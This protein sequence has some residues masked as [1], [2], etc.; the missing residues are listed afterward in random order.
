MTD[1]KMSNKSPEMIDIVFDLDGG[2]LPAA[3]PFA[4]WAALVCRVPQLAEEKFVGVLPLRGTG[5]NE[6]LLLPKRAKL[7][8]RLPTILADHTA[9]RLTGQQLDIAGSTM[10]LGAAKTRPI[11]PYPTIHAQLVTGISD[12]VLFVEHINTQLGEMRIKGKLICGKRRAINDDRQTMQGYSL[13]VHDLTPEASLHLQ[14]VG[15]GEG[16]Q[17]GCGIF[18][19]YKV[20]SG[21]S[22]G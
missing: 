16:R 14:F 20:I 10:R 5:S 19:P 4:L 21:L 12:E 22:E 1:Q 11:Q 2:T 7:V 6:G 8:M 9:A 17:L 13:V 15:L 3:Y 18:V